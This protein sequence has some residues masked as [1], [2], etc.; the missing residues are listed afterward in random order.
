ARDRA[1]THRELAPP[2]GQCRQFEERRVLVDQ[3][4]DALADQHLPALAVPLHVLGAAAG[5]GLAVL[6]LDGGDLLEQRLAVRAVLVA[7]RV[8]RRSQHGH[9]WFLTGWAFTGDPGARSGCR[10][11]ASG[12]TRRAPWPGD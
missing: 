1:G 12:A 3:H 4:L 7:S 11:D 9:V 10:R 5:H 8:E 6:L 2:P